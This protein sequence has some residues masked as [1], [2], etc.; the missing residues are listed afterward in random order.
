MAFRQL[1]QD[2]GL[3]GAAAGK[4]FARIRDDQYFHC[5]APSF[6]KKKINFKPV[7]ATLARRS[8]TA[9]KRG[10]KRFKSLLS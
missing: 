5:P 10:K 1:P 8:A 3:V 2:I 9:R 7:F 4:G 6:L